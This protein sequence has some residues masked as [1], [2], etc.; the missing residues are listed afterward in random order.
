VVDD[1]N[2][3]VDGAYIDGGVATERDRAIWKNGAGNN[4]Y[5]VD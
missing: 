4:Q 2:A 1:D 3:A 5:S